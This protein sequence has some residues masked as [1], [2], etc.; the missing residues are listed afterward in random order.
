[1]TE[2]YNHCSRNTLTI[3]IA[4]N[5]FRAAEISSEMRVEISLFGILEVMEELSQNVISEVDGDER[6]FPVD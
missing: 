3:Y 1:M 4:K 6:P 5:K 2:K